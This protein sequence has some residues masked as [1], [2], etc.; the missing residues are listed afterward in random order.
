MSRCCAKRLPGRNRLRRRIVV[1]V[2]VAD[3]GDRAPELILVLGIE[4]GDVRIRLSGG[5]YRH[6]SRA[7]DHRHVLAGDDLTRDWLIDRWPGSQPEL[8]ILG[9]PR[10]APDAVPFTQVLDLVIILGP[11]LA[12]QG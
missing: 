3:R 12:G 2:T 6:E 9:L 5:H 1:D 11:L 4:H 7:V 10:G 8:G